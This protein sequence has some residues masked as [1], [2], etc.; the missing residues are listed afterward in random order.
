MLVQWLA[1]STLPPGIE[2][3][4]GFYVCGLHVLPVS[5]WGVL[6][7]L[8]FS[9]PAPIRVQVLSCQITRRCEYALRW[10][11]PPSPPLGSLS[12]SHGFQTPTTEG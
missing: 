2:S 8:W 3:A 6:W 5:L 11:D 4:L 7:V 9:P 12:R 10:V 1:L